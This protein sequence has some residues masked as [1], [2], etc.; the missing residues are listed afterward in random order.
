VRA[1]R[2]GRGGK[3]V[4]E[5]QGVTDARDQVAKKLKKTLGVGARVEEE[6][7]VV[8][9]DQRDRLVKWLE[10]QGVRKVVRG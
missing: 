3:T 8:Q 4:T 2:K 7:I 6:L 5:V 10:A 9:G 1:T